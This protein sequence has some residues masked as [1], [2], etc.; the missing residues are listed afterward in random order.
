MPT[1][2]GNG[3]MS[4]SEERLPVSG[5]FSASVSSPDEVSYCFVHVDVLNY[6]Y[7]YSPSPPP[8]RSKRTL[9]IPCIFFS[10]CS[11]EF[12]F[13]LKRAKVKALDCIS[14]HL[15]RNL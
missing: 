6:I 8:F 7:M 9:A 15:K 11:Q 4:T 13:L 12:S 1:A 14:F 10:S 3:G 2:V 5:N